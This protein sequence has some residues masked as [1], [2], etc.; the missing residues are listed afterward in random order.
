M[1]ND[2][3]SPALSGLSVGVTAQNV[4][5]IDHREFVGAPALG[6]I[7]IARLTYRLP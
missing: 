4:L 5:G 6:R 1:Y 7:V 3:E 2:P